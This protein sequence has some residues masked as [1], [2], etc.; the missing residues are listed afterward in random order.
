MKQLPIPTFANKAFAETLVPIKY[1]ELFDQAR[2]WREQ[3]GISLA[4]HDSPRV[5][6]LGIDQQITF[7]M[8]CG[9]LY[10]GGRSGRAAI[11]DS[12]RF[13]E[14][15]YR[16]M[17]HI[18][19]IFMTMDTHTSM[20][21]F[22]RTFIVDQAG[23]SPNPYTMVS[24]D[25]VTAGR[26]S[27]NPEVSPSLGVSYPWLNQWFRHYNK[28]LNEKGQYQ[29]MI[30]PFHAMLG[31][32]GHAF[33]PMIEQA[34]FFHT[35]VRQSQMTHRIKGGNPLSENYSVFMQEV[36]EDEAGNPI[37]PI[38][39]ALLTTLSNFDMIVVGGQAKSHCLAWTVRNLLDNVPADVAKRVYL[40]EDCTSPVVT[41]AFDFTDLADEAFRKFAAAGMHVVKST[42]PMNTWP[43]NPF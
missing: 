1:D 27:V 30:W 15:I 5:A 42:D 43:D 41:P 32:I 21:I 8:P 37:I 36:M 26:W 7:C 6:L 3:H 35:C 22:H 38:D 34:I 25:D 11:Q 23:K 4:V 20:Q 13:A 16:N 40:L 39:T 29:L 14:F 2:P 12:V 24:M 19:G 18:T 9:E 33:V 31:G 10:V 17:A 28:R